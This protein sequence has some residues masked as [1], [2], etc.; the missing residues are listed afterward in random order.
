MTRVSIEQTKGPLVLEFGAVW[1]GH[2]QAARTVVVA[3]FVNYPH[4]K[5]IKVEDGKGKRFGRSYKV[6]LW[7]T[8]VFINNGVE[9]SR[10]V[11]PDNSQLI[12]DALKVITASHQ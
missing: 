4:V 10:L 6:K 3:A 11:R 1:C 2:C 12:M 7:P 5:H 9:V 8:L